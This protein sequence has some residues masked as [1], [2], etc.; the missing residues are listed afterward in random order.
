MAL[1]RQQKFIFILETICS[2][3]NDI[4][5]CRIFLHL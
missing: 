5:R 2:D 1:T 3:G 4:N